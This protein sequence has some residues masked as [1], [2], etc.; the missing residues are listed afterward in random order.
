MQ[1]LKIEKGGKM[2]DVY[3]YIN[4]FFNTHI[5]TVDIYNE[6]SL[7]HEMGIFL[8]NSISGYKIQFERNLSFFNIREKLEK[9]E[10]DIC[11]FNS[12][13]SEKYAIELKYPTNGQ[14]PEQMYSFIKDIRFMEQLKEKGF[15]NTFCVVLVS[16]RPFYNGAK[17]NGI[18]KYFR[19]EHSIYGDIYKPTGSLKNIDYIS[20]N[21]KYDFVW[22]DIATKKEKFYIIKI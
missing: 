10:I 4:E 20:V 21:G 3:K 8:R 14:F 7:Q 6:I 1:K 2:I 9:K 17:Q 11:I 19:K 22:S 16:Q 13:N 15:T 5:Q 12:N 18:Y